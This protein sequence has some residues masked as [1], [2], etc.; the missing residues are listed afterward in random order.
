VFDATLSSGNIDSVLDFSVADDT[1]ALNDF[2]FS[3]LAPGTLKS[4]EFVSGSRAVTA[5][6]HIIYNSGTGALLYDAD[7][8]GQGGAIQFATLGRGLALTA[9]DFLVV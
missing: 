1:I 8:S 5:D 3:V 7:G 9:A 4:A 6:Q 2:I